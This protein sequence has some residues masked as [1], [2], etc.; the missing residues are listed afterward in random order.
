[1]NVQ[2]TAR[3]IAALVAV[4]L[5]AGCTARNWY[6]GVQQNHRQRCELVPASE[7][8]ECLAQH[9]DRYE[10]YQRKRSEVVE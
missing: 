1:M 5:S 7:R 10:D 8:E 2:W 9:D 6:E 4:T 3:A